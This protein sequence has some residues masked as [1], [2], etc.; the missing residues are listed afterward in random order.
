MPVYVF[1]VVLVVSQEHVL[2]YG[3]LDTQTKTYYDN[4]VSLFIIVCLL[5][6][7]PGVF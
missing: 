6:C 5:Y 7:G 4:K 2:Y 3:T 1:A